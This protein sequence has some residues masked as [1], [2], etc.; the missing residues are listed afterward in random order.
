MRGACEAYAGHLR[1]TQ[2][3]REYASVCKLCNTVLPRTIGLLSGCGAAVRGR[4]EQ[5]ST[6]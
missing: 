1:Q 3:P 2:K 6:A 5:G 4:L